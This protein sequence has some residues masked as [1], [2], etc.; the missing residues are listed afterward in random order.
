MKM[1]IPCKETYVFGHGALLAVWESNK[2]SREA[3]ETYIYAK[4]NADH[5]NETI[6]KTI[7]TK[8]T[9]F[10]NYIN[11][12]LPRCCRNIKR[13]RQKHAMWLAGNMTILSDRNE[14]PQ[15]K[16]GRP[17]LSYEAAGKR[18]KIKLASELAVENENS[19]PLLL[20]AANISARKSTVNEI[21]KRSD[22]TE[23]LAPSPIT[24]EKAFAFF[25]EN[26]FTKQQYIN[27][28]QISKQHGCDIYPPYSKIAEEKLKCRPSGI[29]W[30]ENEAKV[31]RAMDSSD[32][33]LSSFCSTKTN[34]MPLPAEVVD[35]L[36]S[37]IIS[38]GTEDTDEENCNDDVS[39]TFEI[40]LE[41][42][43]PDDI[44]N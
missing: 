33:L 17:K 27:V 10:I 6:I 32:P 19:T 16:G 43:V 25:M 30:T 41:E 36:D 38:P 22:R 21:I 42:E 13:F 26:G 35:L 1:E 4:L 7:S 18:L 2:R 34:R 8:I 14:S 3:L 37:P 15:K 12:H 39:D 9:N 5:Q 24:S 23:S 20:H 40:E 31:H 11:K 29:A 28:K 44:E